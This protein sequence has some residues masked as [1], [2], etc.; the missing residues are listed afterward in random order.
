MLSVKMSIGCL[1]SSE[2]RT[3]ADHDLITCFSRACAFTLNNSDWCIELKI[4]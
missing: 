1:N 3:E 2:V 4:Q